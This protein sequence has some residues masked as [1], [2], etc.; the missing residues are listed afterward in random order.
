MTGA[1]PPLAPPAAASVRTAP[2]MFG[3]LQRHW[4]RLRLLP[5]LLSRCLAIRIFASAPQRYPPSELNSGVDA[6][7]Q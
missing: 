2:P 4:R 3:D 7:H 5:A 6:S 1:T